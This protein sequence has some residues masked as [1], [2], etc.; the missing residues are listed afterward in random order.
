MQVLKNNNKHLEKRPPC[1]PRIFH[2]IRDWPRISNGYVLRN[3]ND[4]GNSLVPEELMDLM[5]IDTLSRLLSWLTGDQV[6]ILKVGNDT[7]I[8]ERERKE[9]FGKQKNASP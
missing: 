2:F 7:Y 1:I 8:A 5:T 6:N 4:Y 9:S 3:L